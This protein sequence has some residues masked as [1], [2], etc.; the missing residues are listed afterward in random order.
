[1]KTGNSFLVFFSNLFNKH[2]IID[3]RLQVFCR[4]VI[5]SVTAANISG[6]FDD[7]LLPLKDNYNAYFGSSKDKTIKKAVK[8]GSTGTLNSKVKLFA[9]AVRSKYH[10]IA[11]VYPEGTAEYKEFFVN[12]LSG[13]SKINRKNV[14][15]IVNAFAAAALKYKDQLGGDT[16]AALF[17]GYQTSISASLDDQTGNKSA[18]KTVTKEII[19]ERAPVENALMSVMFAVG[20]KFWPD[21]NKCMSFFDFSLLFAPHHSTGND[22]KG[23]LKPMATA[24]CL[25]VLLKDTNILELSAFAFP[26]SYYL[27]ETK[28]GPAVGT[29][30]QVAAN[31]THST[32][33]AEFAAPAGQYLNVTNISDF[34]VNWE[35][36]VE[37]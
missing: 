14:L 37:G 28:N 23:S 12:G 30:I 4:F 34:K 2:G 10:L 13:I 24:N 6:I 22:F 35:V 3:S 16:F 11:S 25:T 8:E 27:S 17:T 18:V 9:N 21:E 26:L 1:M 31:T 36:K 15:Q 5:A 7:V 33:F 20:H 29:K 32:P 19:T